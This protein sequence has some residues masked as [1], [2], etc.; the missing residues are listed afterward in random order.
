MP[1]RDGTGPWWA[2]NVRCG[3]H[4][5]GFISLESRTKY[6]VLAVAIP[7]IA[8]LIKDLSSPNGLIREGARKLFGRGNSFK[9]NTAVHAKFKVVDE[10]PTERMKEHEDSN[11]KR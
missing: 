4:A 7:V 8:G 10:A 5:R 3:T 1:N 6:K 2:Q 11:R 9:R